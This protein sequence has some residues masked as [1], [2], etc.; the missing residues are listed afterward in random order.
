MTPSTESPSTRRDTGHVP[1]TRPATPKY[2]VTGDTGTVTTELRTRGVDARS[3]LLLGFTTDVLAAE[4][5]TTPDDALRAAPTLLPGFERVAAGI[6]TDDQVILM[7]ADD[8]GDAT[9]GL[10]F[11]GKLIADR[12]I[13]DVVGFYGYNNATRT[14]RAYVGEIDEDG[15][16][17][18]IKPLQIDRKNICFVAKLDGNAYY[19]TDD[20][21]VLDEDGKKI[22]DLNEM[23][24][25]GK[26][27][28]LVAAPDKLLINVQVLEAGF[29][30]VAI[31]AKTGTMTKTGIGEID[32]TDAT[33]FFGS[34]IVRWT[35]EYGYVRENEMNAGWTAVSFAGLDQT[36]DA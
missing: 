8:L 3:I 34:P 19:L 1:L 9:K 18:N 14:T 13:D 28:N 35:K 24:I 31:D 26:A 10:D 16:V 22:A 7:A 27:I 23:G 4:F 36:P 6:R 25:K 5:A 12:Q 32:D 11:A 2:G 17:V 30:V 15:N 33:V 29:R 21:T 20:G